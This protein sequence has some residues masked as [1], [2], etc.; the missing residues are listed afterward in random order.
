MARK[1][2][3]YILKTVAIDTAAARTGVAYLDGV[4]CLQ[5]QFLL[6]GEKPSACLL[7]LIDSTLTKCGVRVEDL[8]LLVV[9]IGPGSF[10]GIRIGMAAAQGLSFALSLPVVGVSSL[11]VLAGSVSSGDQIIV[12]IDA[13]HGEV[14][15]AAFENRNGVM[16]RLSGPL[17]ADPGSLLKGINKKSVFIG[18]GTIKFRAEIIESL[19]DMAVFNDEALNFSSPAMLGRI[20]VGIFSAKRIYKTPSL[21]PNY[22][23]TFSLDKN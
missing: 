11:D 20:G 12:W 16:K 23:K 21:Q 5:E 7:P 4:D 8:G 17:V 15:H 6:P 9:N 13:K 14:Y 22:V 18:E 2:K 1:D 10:T 19:G 3:T